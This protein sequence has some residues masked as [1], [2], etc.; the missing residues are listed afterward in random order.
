MVDYNREIVDI[1]KANGFQ[2]LRTGK[3]SH[4]SGS[5]LAAPSE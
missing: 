2:L 4:E 3:G 1:L 5:I